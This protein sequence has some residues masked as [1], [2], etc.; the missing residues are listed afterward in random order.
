M[1]LKKTIVLWALL[2]FALV[3]AFVWV[4]SRNDQRLIHMKVVDARTGFPVTNVNVRVNRS[5]E[6]PVLSSMKFLPSRWRVRLRHE[7]LFPANGIFYVNPPSKHS[8]AKP[9]CVFQ[10][11]RYLYQGLLLESIGQSNDPV[12]IRLTPRQPLSHD[13]NLQFSI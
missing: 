1:K 13:P 5:Y 12:I 3:L 2:A 6:I 7:Y 8:V 10:A 11:D 9:V 4:R